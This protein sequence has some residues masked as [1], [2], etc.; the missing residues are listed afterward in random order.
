MVEDLR[1]REWIAAERREL[2]A[3]LTALPSESRRIAC[4]WSWTDWPAREA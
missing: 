1:L 4:A 3:V 2:A